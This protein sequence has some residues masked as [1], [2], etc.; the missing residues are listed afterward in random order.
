MEVPSQKKGAP[1]R[2][3]SYYS[4]RNRENNCPGAFRHH[5]MQKVDA[6]IIA[7]I[8]PY[9]QNPE[10][11]RASLADNLAD[12]KRESKRLLDA[13]AAK[14]K[15]IVDLRKLDLV[16]ATL[17]Q[18]CFHDKEPSHALM[19]LFPDR[20]LAASKTLNTA[21]MT[22]AEF[23]EVAPR[24]PIHGEE[25]A[26]VIGARELL[27]VVQTLVMRVTIDR[28]HNIVDFVLLIDPGRLQKGDSER[29]LTEILARKGDPG[30]RQ[31]ANLKCMTSPS[32][33]SYTLPSSR[34][35]PASLAAPSDP[36]L[37]RSS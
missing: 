33:T 30:D 19:A 36:A 6:A 34:S 35:R 4:C 3:R 32:L 9:L 24:T 25:G 27:D 15:R 26:Q 13:R 2:L 12:R 31:T 18:A 20:V 17:T 22:A 1:K 8:F 5:P 37:I 21:K 23:Y 7:R 29:G 11:V 10:L 14:E 16:V 28:D